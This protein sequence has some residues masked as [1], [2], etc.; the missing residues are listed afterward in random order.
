MVCLLT[1]TGESLP[2]L[3]VPQLKLM[4]FEVVMVV[5]TKIMVCMGCDTI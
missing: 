4:R 1:L 5:I 2:L 3:F